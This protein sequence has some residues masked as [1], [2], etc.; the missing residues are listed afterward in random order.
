MNNIGKRTQRLQ[1]TDR[2]SRGRAQRRVMDIVQEDM[3]PVESED[4]ED[5]EEDAECWGRWKQVIGCGLA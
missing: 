4:A 1:L 3:K 5:E 2:R